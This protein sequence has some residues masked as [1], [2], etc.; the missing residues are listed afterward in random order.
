MYVDAGELAIPAG[1]ALDFGRLSRS[2][3]GLLI[4]VVYDPDGSRI[5]MIYT[6]DPA[7]G[8]TLTSSVF[9]NGASITTCNTMALG[10]GV[11]ACMGTGNGTVFLATPDDVGTDWR[12]TASG[13]VPGSSGAG[14]DPDL[15]AIDGNHLIVSVPNAAVVMSL[16]ES[17]FSSGFQSH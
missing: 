4:P 9:R 12:I 3:N 10:N 14:F 2:G 7:L 17:I 11:A 15:M 1:M 13:S 6:L 16:S 5:G 8:W